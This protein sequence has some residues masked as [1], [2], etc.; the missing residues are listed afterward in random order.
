MS[1]PVEI[2]QANPN[3]P[4]NRVQHLFRNAGLPQI[5]ALQRVTS[6]SIQQAQKKNNRH[7]VCCFLDFCGSA[8][9]WVPVHILISML[10]RACHFLEARCAVFEL[11]G[12]R[13]GKPPIWGVSFLEGLCPI[14]IFLLAS[15]KNPPNSGYH[16]K[17][18]PFAGSPRTPKSGG[19][20]SRAWP[21]RTSLAGLEWTKGTQHLQ[22]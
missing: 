18:N 19:S 9:S 13:K 3:T 14:E 11:K 5:R 15:L 2:V 21:C 8:S 1:T 20:A 22:K 7:A 12:N 16:P 6:L 17:T 4:F 10:I